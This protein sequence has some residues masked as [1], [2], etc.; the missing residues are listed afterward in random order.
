MADTTNKYNLRYPE[1]GDNIDAQQIEDL[2][3]DVEDTFEKQTEVSAQHTVTLING[4]QTNAQNPLVFE[5]VG[6]I[7]YCRGEVYHNSAS[8]DGHFGNI[9]SAYRP[10]F[11]RVGPMPVMATIANNIAAFIIWDD[12]R[13]TLSGFSARSGTPGY[14]CVAS[15]VR[16]A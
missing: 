10:T 15:Y 16:E 12:G 6:N 5:R 9:P 11:Q 3:N 8:A 14:G 13:L 4:W 7:V 1:A 2:A